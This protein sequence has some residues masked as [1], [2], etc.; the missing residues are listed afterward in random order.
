MPPKRQSGGR[1]VDGK[2]AYD[3]SLEYKC[4]EIVFLGEKMYR[5]LKVCV[6]LVY[7]KRPEALIK[8]LDAGSGVLV[9]KSDEYKVE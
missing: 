1:P 8:C 7:L 6:V 5:F 3:S 2:H 4:P 9:I